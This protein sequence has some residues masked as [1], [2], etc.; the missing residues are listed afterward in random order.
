VSPRLEWANDVQTKPPCPVH[1]GRAR[2]SKR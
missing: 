1:N 2:K